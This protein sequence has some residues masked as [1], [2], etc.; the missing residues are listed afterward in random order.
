MVIY[1]TA[2]LK[3]KIWEK[4]QL[5]EFKEEIDVSMM[6]DFNNPFSVI[7][8]LEKKDIDLNDTMNYLDVMNICRTLHPPKLQHI[9]LCVHGMFP[10]IDHMMENKANP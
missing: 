9:F 10:N 6:I 3:Y 2:T 4:Q 5:R 8:H 1:L 7:E